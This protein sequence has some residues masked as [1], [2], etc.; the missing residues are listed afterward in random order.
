MKRETM[1]K[2]SELFSKFSDEERS[3]SFAVQNLFDQTVRIITQNEGKS[4]TQ[5]R[6]IPN[7]PTEKEDA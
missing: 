6:R 3:S 4:D 1:Q 5:P 7:K 2:L